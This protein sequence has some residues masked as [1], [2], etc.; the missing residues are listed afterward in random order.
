[1]AA[2]FTGID[3][4]G[5]VAEAA[6]LVAEEEGLVQDLIGLRSGAEGHRKKLQALENDKNKAGE[7]R[8][9]GLTGVLSFSASSLPAELCV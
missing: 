5:V 7:W 9:S 4:N 2:M 3:T 8:H 1:M 6:R